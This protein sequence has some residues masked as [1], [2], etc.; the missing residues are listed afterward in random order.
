MQNANLKMTVQNA[1]FG[2]FRPFMMIKLQNSNLKMTV[3]NSKLFKF[4]STFHSKNTGSDDV[5]NF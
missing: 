3:Q 1:K 4:F 2:F 5:G